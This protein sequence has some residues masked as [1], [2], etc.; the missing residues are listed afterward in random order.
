[1]E[2]K[3]SLSHRDALTGK[4]VYEANEKS[5]F[6]NNTLSTNLSWNDLI[7]NTSGSLPNTQSACMPEYAVSNLLKVIKRFGNNKLVTFTSRNEWTSL[8]EKLAIIHDG[9]NYGQNIKQHS[10]YTDETASLGFVINKVLLSLYT[11]LSGYFR[12]LNTEL[13]GVGF[14]D[15]IGA[16]A[17]TTDYLRVFASPKFEWSYKKLELTL[18]LPVSLYSYF[19]LELWTIVQ[20]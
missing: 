16:E 10:F 18:N 5:Y 1:M 19:F 12:N 20:T 7:L 15:L 4:F 11:G 13:N 14:A 2:D 9:V 3:N 17:L 8:P 6:L